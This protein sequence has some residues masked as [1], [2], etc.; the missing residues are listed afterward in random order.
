MLTKFFIGNTVYCK[1][2][3]SSII[4]ARDENFETQLPFEII[5]YDEANVKYVLLI[6]KYFSIKNSWNIIEE[7]LGKLHINSNHLDEKAISIYEDKIVSIKIK[8]TNLDG[9]YCGRCKEFFPM[10]EPNQIN[11]DFK[12]W[13]CRSNLFR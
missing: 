1:I 3:G 4:L 12:C 10:A 8:K 11:G 6:P 5:G 2:R 13:S 9:M 7:H